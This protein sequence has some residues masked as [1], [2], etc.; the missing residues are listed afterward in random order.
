MWIA[1]TDGFFSVVEDHFDRR[2]LFVRARSRDD[3]KNLAATLKAE[4]AILSTPTAD[5][6]WRLRVRR[7]TWKKYLGRAVDALSYGNFKGAISARAPARAAIY[8]TVWS[9]LWRIERENEPPPAGV[10]Q[11][12]LE[13]DPPL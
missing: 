8:S 3:L 1:T 6:P 13:G 4:P 11:L 7:R 9:V 5:Y 12:E 2:F 10:E